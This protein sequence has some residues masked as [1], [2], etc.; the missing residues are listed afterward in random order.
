MIEN[1]ETGLPFARRGITG[2]NP[3]F[4]RIHHFLIKQI[5]KCFDMQH[6]KLN[7]L[8]R[9]QRGTATSS[10]PEGKKLPRHLSFP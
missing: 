8:S 1:G 10:T 2:S 4:N 6:K 9:S 3:P 7:L 5:K